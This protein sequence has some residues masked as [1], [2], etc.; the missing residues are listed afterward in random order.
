M[1]TNMI[2]Q[3][4]KMASNNYTD[5]SSIG[6]Q[7]RQELRASVSV[8]G[9][10]ARHV[11]ASSARRGRCRG[12][13][14]RRAGEPRRC[15]THAARIGRRLR[16][17]PL[18]ASTPTMG[19][20]TLMAHRSPSPRGVHSPS[21]SP[22]FGRRRPAPRLPWHPA[23]STR[24]GAQNVGWDENGPRVQPITHASVSAGSACPR[25]VPGSR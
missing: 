24:S 19:E 17:Y 9:E 8:Q 16:R 2:G 5:P 13:C 1:L 25:L 11:P 22:L 12:L 21:R 10:G 20:V 6:K 23:A 18:V 3:E 15:G 7:Q 14:E 4:R